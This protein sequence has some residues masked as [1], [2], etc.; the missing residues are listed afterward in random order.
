MCVVKERVG[1]KLRYMQASLSYVLPISAQQ[2]VRYLAS[3]CVSLLVNG[4]GA[5]ASASYSVVTRVYDINVGV[6]QIPLVRLAIMR[7][8]A[9]GRIRRAE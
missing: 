7:R 4:S 6:Y 9:W 2:M 8:N 3:L 5:F 1:F